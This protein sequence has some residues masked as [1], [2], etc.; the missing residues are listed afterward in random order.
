VRDV[1]ELAGLVV[2]GDEQP[3]SGAIDELSSRNNVV[4]TVGLAGGERVL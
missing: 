4:E 3:S 2:A 1:W